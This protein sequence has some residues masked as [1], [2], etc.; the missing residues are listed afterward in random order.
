MAKLVSSPETLEE[1]EE[2]FNETARALEARHVAELEDADER[3]K[4]ACE[5]LMRFRDTRKGQL[6]AS[7][8]SLI[9]ATRAAAAWLEC[10][11]NVTVIRYEIG[12]V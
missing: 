2:F 5:L 11:S 9:D 3:H 12:T 4:V 6:E 1:L 7:R 8:A 10:D